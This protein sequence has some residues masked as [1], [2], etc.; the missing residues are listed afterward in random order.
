MLEGV[1]VK[2]LF[3]FLPLSQMSWLFQDSL[4]GLCPPRPPERWQKKNVQHQWFNDLTI[5]KKR[6]C[7]NLWHSWN[8]NLSITIP[9][10]S[11]SLSGPSVVFR[12]RKKISTW[13][14]VLAAPGLGCHCGKPRGDL[15]IHG[16][17]RLWKAPFFSWAVVFDRWKKWPHGKEDD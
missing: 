16:C 7:G 2:V 6:Y 15:Q 3:V 10:L 4:H 14:R 13:T 9:Y 11:T 12:S 8:I 5:N 1:F 17:R